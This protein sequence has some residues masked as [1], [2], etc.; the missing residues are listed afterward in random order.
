MERVYKV[1]CA[2]PGGLGFRTGQDTLGFTLKYL[3]CRTPIMTLA[4]SEI[5]RR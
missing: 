1:L 5:L 4:I 2:G 3:N